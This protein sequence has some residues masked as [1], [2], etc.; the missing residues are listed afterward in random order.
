M[1][2]QKR[3]L[4]WFISGAG[5]LSMFSRLV[6]DHYLTRDVVCCD[7]GC[8]HFDSKFISVNDSHIVA[9]VTHRWLLV[10]DPGKSRNFSS[11]RCNI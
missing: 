4:W 11:P 5:L 3:E 7:G 8:Q 2:S 9:D 6:K 10:G 1:M